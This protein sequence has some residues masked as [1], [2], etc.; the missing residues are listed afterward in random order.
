MLIKYIKLNY[1]SELIT[2]ALLHAP[3]HATTFRNVSHERNFSVL[4]VFVFVCLLVACGLWLVV[5][6]VCLVG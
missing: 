4:G 5:A 3:R 2:H 6:A 1:H